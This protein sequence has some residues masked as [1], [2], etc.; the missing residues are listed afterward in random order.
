V[1]W[2]IVAAV[3]GGLLLVA[4][5]VS[6]ILAVVFGALRYSDP[7]RF[8]TQTAMHD[9]RVIAKLGSPVS[10]GWLMNGSVKEQNDS[11][12]ADLS[13]PVHGS[14]HKG[15]IHVVATKS[16]GEWT[17]QQL[18]LTV[19]DAPDQLDVLLPETAVPK[20]K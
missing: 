5:F 19:E 10:T 3:S 1:A 20:E 18:T 12:E 16:G 14:I 13:I 4:L 8:A 11:G 17:Y 15:A 6:T 2:I 7:Y 9:P